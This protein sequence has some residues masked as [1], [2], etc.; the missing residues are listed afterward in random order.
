V[1]PGGGLVG[2]A[3]RV[4]TPCKVNRSRTKVFLHDGNSSELSSTLGMSTAV[5]AVSSQDLSTASVFS[6]QE[7]FSR[8]SHDMAVRP[9]T[10]YP[11]TPVAGRQRRGA[12]PGRTVERFGGDS[13][14]LSLNSDPDSCLANP[15]PSSQALGQGVR[16]VSPK[17]VLEGQADSADTRT[18]ADKASG[19]QRHS[20]ELQQELT[21][22]PSFLS[23]DGSEASIITAGSCSCEHQS[24][25][26]IGHAPPGAGSSRLG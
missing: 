25:C 15:S 14:F 22:E 3:V 5:D 11:R 2:G 18:V 8:S 17:K 9:R 23:E 7:S 19:E 20:T 10:V 4:K 13:S 1:R 26:A 6:A 12:T 24:D 21:C 16:D